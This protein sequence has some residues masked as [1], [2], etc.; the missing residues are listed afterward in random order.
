MDAIMLS[1]FNSREREE[2]DWSALF[3]TADPRFTILEV[4]KAN[5]NASSGVL[6]ARW[7]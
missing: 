1:L 5:E 7:K 3:T 4:K 2:S 6:V